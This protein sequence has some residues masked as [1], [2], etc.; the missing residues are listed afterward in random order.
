MT[1]KKRNR[2]KRGVK[3]TS[4]LNRISP[5]PHVSV[6]EPRRPASA[7]ARAHLSP[8]LAAGSLHTRWTPKITPRSFDNDPNRPPS[9]PSP[10]PAPPRMG[11][12][13]LALSPLWM[14][15]PPALDRGDAGA[16]SPGH[17]GGIPARDNALVDSPG[18]PIRFATIPSTKG[19]PPVPRNLIRFPPHPPSLGAI[20]LNGS[21]GPPCSPF[22]VFVSTTI[23]APLLI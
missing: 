20:S 2:Q 4:P 15:C 16:C 9:S 1:T 7:L 12:L 21:S 10:W 17:P 19:H 3:G 18:S 11:F 23:Y 13:G 5:S 14:D 8:R 6:H 22:P